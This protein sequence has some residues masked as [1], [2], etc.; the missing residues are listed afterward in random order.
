MITTSLNVPEQVR[1][2]VAKYFT[3][4][5]GLKNYKPIAVGHQNGEDEYLYVVLARQIH[6]E[7][8]VWTCWNES[9]Q[10]LNH[11]HYNLTEAEAMRI[12][13]DVDSLYNKRPNEIKLVDIAY[14]CIQAL[15][16]EGDNV[17]ALRFLRDKVKLTEEECEYFGVDYDE[18]Q[19]A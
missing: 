4:S 15:L 3:E 12:F 7:W 1:K 5:N 16:I 13:L 11:G 6:G 2:N 17:H 8:A 18:M 9:T 14:E 19:E 10:S